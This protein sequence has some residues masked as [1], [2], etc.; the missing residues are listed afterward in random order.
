MKPLTIIIA[1]QNPG[2]ITALQKS[3]EDLQL[4]AEIVSLPIEPMVSPMPITLGELKSGALERAKR[5]YSTYCK[6]ANKCREKI[7][8]SL[9]LEGGFYFSPP[10]W[11][12]TGMVAA[13]SSQK[14]FITKGFE[15]PVNPTL[16]S[17]VI[18]HEMELGEVI[19]NL[20]LKKNTKHH[21]GAVY[22]LTNKAITR[23]EAFKHQVLLALSPFFYD[24]KY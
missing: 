19:D 4:H 15:I 11:Y 13:Y 5:A 2:K 17:K 8:I 18:D 16:V 24:F 20:V 9:G 6:Q 12:L 21:E 3:I 7:V 14:F 22:Y 23:V 1:T 10:W